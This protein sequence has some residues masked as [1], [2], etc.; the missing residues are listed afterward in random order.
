[1]KYSFSCIDKLKN[2]PVAKLLLLVVLCGTM[3]PGCKKMLDVDSSHTVAEK[4]M[5]NTHEDTRSALIGVYGLMRAALADN[6][7]YWMYGELR[8]GDF[9]AVRSTRMVCE[10]L[11]QSSQGWARVRS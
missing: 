11:N 9:T 6:D 4:N 7:A 3:L 5:W 10:T 2:A 8:S 1:M